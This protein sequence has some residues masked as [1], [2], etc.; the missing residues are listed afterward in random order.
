LEKTP[1]PA[2]ASYR[3][4]PLKEEPPA[5]LAR[6]G[7]VIELANVSI[8]TEGATW[9]VRLTWRATAKLDTDY[10]AFVYIC[11][12]GC[13]G[14][15]PLAQDDGQPG[16]GYYPTRLWRPGDVVIDVHTLRLPSDPPGIPEIAV[17]LYTWPEMERLPVTEASGSSDDSMVILPLGR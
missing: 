10:T 13:A 2:Y 17:G 1:Y 16:D 5:A 14:E 4:E 3:I 12:D 11:D 8:E 7:D 9:D 6:F 15:Q